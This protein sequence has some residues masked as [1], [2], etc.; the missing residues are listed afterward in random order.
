MRVGG[1]FGPIT[2]TTTE[3]TREP[4]LPEAEPKSVQY[5]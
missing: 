1:D 3:E 5:N 2:S 4:S